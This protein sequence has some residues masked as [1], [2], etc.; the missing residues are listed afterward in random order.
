MGGRPEGALLAAA[1]ACAG[2]CG[3]ALAQQTG[4]GIRWDAARPLT[5][6]DFQGPVDPGAGPRTAAL[7][8]ASLSLG[9][10]L[11]VRRGRR[12]EYEITKIETSAEFHPRQS[13]VRNQARTETVLEHEQGHFD[14]TEVFRSVLEREANELVGATRSCGTDAD[15]AAIETEVGELVAHMRESIFAELDQVQRQYDAQTG[16]GT[17]PQ[18]QRTW[19]ERIRRAL[20]RGAW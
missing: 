4:E 18:V 13:W 5:W 15:M 8:A 12:C 1:A 7:T 3:S 6:S 16:H 17:L 14:L 2:L 20:G 10:E 9:Y 19:T 11:E